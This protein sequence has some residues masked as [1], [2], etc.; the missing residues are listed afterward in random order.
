M[1]KVK[2]DGQW[3]LYLYVYFSSCGNQAILSEIYQIPNFTLKLK[4]KVM[5]NVKSDGHIW[6]LG[7]NRYVC[8]LFRGNQTVLAEREQIRGQ[9]HSESQTNGHIWGLEFSRYLFA[10]CFI[11]IGPFSVVI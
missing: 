4:V 11:A 5:A 3:G 10:F 1:A 2:L 8:F 9:A 6:G 7:F